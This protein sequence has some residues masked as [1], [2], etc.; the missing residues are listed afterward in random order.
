MAREGDRIYVVRGVETRRRANG[1]SWGSVRVK[2]RIEMEE[3][4]GRRRGEEKQNEY[5]IQS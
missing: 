4:G 2:D 1:Q 5:G 3:R